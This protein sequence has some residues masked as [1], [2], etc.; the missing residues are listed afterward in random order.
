MW[1]RSVRSSGVIV[2]AA[3]VAVVGLFLLLVNLAEHRNQTRL[4]I[5]TMLFL[6]LL[7]CS[8]TSVRAHRS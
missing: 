7:L 6:P 4:L 5:E 8:V 2:G 3:M 1:S